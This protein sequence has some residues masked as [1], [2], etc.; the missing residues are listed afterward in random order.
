MSDPDEFGRGIGERNLDDRRARF[1]DGGGLDPGNAVDGA[2][3]LVGTGKIAVI[4]GA[5]ETEA[6]EC[7]DGG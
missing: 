7:G 6:S 1:A 5:V 4:F 3:D 2:S